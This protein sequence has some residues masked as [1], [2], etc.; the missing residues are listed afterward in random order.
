MLSSDDERCKSVLAPNGTLYVDPVV[1]PMTPIILGVDCYPEHDPEAEWNLDA[2]LMHD[3][4]PARP[5]IIPD[6][7]TCTDATARKLEAWCARG[8]NLVCFSGAGE[9]DEFGAQGNLCP[10]GILAPLFG[11]ELADYWQLEIA[12]SPAFDPAA[13]R[14]RRTS[15]AGLPRTVREVQIDRARLVFDARHGEVCRVVKLTTPTG[16]MPVAGAGA[17]PHHGRRILGIAGV[18]DCARAPLTNPGDIIRNGRQHATMW[19]QPCTCRK[20]MEV[21]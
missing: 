18:G 16:A 6:L 1:S 15:D 12:S 8:G 2:K 21:K 19:M 14:N 17:R 10:P 4:D 7:D 13:G 11:V 3:W 9:Q 20:Q 5:L